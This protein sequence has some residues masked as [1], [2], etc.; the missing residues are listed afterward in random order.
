MAD[1]LNDP[2]NIARSLLLVARRRGLYLQYRRP[3]RWWGGASINER[4]KAL[5]NSLLVTC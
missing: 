1:S 5:Q 3:N 4:N 2:D